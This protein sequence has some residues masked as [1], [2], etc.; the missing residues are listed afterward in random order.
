M[1][2]LVLTALVLADAGG[3]VDFRPSSSEASVPALFRLEAA[4]FRYETTPV[5]ETARHKVSTVRFPSPIES[6]D[7]VN[8]VVHAEFFEPTTPTDRK[9]AGVIVLHILGADFALS[10]F[11]ASRLADSGVSALFVKLPYYGERQP[12]GMG[13][14]RRLLATDVDR[15]RL[16]MRQGICDVRRAAAWLS[17]R[18]EIDPERLGVT[19]VSLGGIVAAVSSA[20]GPEFRSSALLLAGGD[21]AD[22]LWRMPQG[23]EERAR[24]V[25]SGKTK[26][27]LEELTRPFD[28]LTY[29][30]RLRGK[31]VLMMAG[32]TDEVVPPESAKALWEK[33]GKPTI[34][35]FDCGHYSAIGYLLPAVREMVD[36]FADA[37]KS[38]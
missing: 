7:P 12:P 2:V 28:P 10:R 32:A 17:A 21:L 36:F 38:E 23:A 24:W 29:A 4:T 34:R 27:D 9:R 25:A 33:A 30:E 35:W 8:N 15:A 19:G 20:V 26:A 13:D 18:P 6:P 5:R 1:S 31:K 22:L 14:Q 37:P 3:V 16:A 11:M